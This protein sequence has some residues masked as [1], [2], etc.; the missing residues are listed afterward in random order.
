MQLRRIKQG[1]SVL[2]IYFVMVGIVANILILPKILSNG[3]ISID[4]ETV[5]IKAG[6]KSSVR[7]EE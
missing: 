5:Y 4:S 2:V 7:D 3:L 6:G 1:I